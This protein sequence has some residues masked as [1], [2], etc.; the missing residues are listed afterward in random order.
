MERETL[1]RTSNEVSPP[2]REGDVQSEA[3]HAGSDAGGDA[4]GDA[5]AS[6]QHVQ[7]KGR[8]RDPELAREAARVRWSRRCE[9]DV[10]ED[11]VDAGA[12]E[13]CLIVKVPVK[14]A[15]IVRALEKEAMKGLPQAGRELRAWLERYPPEDERVRVEDLSA[16]RRR[17]ILAWINARLDAEEDSGGGEA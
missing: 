13:Q 9:R 8:F 2:S 10:K 14:V 1:I 3:A 5:G 16:E 4:G 6:R 17:K 11:E 15:P 7:A 12:E